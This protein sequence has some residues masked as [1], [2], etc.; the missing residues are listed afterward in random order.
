MVW[1]HWL[2]VDR[3]GSCQ[4][5][6][7][8]CQ[9]YLQGGEGRGGGEMGGKWRWGVSVVRCDRLMTYEGEPWPLPHPVLPG[10][11]TSA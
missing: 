9:G 1:R 3:G 6:L 4:H 7:H 8:V 10:Y 2:T 5:S 11:L